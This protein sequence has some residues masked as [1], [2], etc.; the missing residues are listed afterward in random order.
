MS[1]SPAS[2]HWLLTMA[3]TATALGA[4][5][6]ALSQETEFEEIVVTG[7][8]KGGQS[9]TETLSPVD[10]LSGELLS[11]QAAFDLTDGLPKITPSLNTQRF[12]IADGTAFIRPVTLRNLS[13]DHTLVLMNGVRR[14]RSALVNLQQ[15]YEAAQ[16]SPSLSPYEPA[17]LEER[18]EA[19]RASRKR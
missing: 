1:F 5:A 17:E 15:L 2:K 18:L 6:A 7:T 8:R 13:P 3:A 11:E 10:M 9:P 4:P 14:H 12:P 19:V 16:R